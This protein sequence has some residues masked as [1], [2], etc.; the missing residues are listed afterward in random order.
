[1]S[2]KIKKYPLIGD[3]AYIRSRR[4]RKL[5]LSVRPGRGV[6]ITLPWYAPWKEA[7]AFVLANM[8]WLKEKLGRA[9]EHQ[10]RAGRVYRDGDQVMPGIILE[11]ASFEG[12]CFTARLQDGTLRVAYPAGISSEDPALQSAIRETIDHA[13]RKKALEYLPGR[14]AE[15]ARGHGF[16]FRRVS[17]RRSR[18]RWGSCSP[19]NNIN[20][21]IYLMQLPAH[22][23]DYV[24]LHELVHTRQRNHSPAFW[25]LLDEHTGNNARAL[26]REIKKYRITI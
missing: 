8:E 21:S 18:T 25:A 26:A 10:E 16:T 19:A 5:T 6:R 2:K 3:V 14:T 24:I 15:L 4:A 20:L 23:I 1:M 7:E 11:L 22:L 13:L 17:I 12:E 9:R